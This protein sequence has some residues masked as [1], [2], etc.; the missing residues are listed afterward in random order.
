MELDRKTFLD[1]IDKAEPVRSF[2]GELADIMYE[3]LDAYFFGAITEDM[4]IDHL[5]NR[6]GLWLGE[7]N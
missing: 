7:R 2:P 5:G 3:E 1:F 4:L 6:I